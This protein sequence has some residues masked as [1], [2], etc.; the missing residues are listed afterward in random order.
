MAELK[1]IPHKEIDVDFP[2]GPAIKQNQWGENAYI[3]CPPSEF[4]FFA[5]CSTPN[6]GLEKESERSFVVRAYAKDGDD[7]VHIGLPYSFAKEK[8]YGT[9]PVTQTVEQGTMLAVI[10]YYHVSAIDAIDKMKKPLP[11]AK[12]DGST[13][14]IEDAPE[15]VP[16]GLNSTSQ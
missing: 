2:L 1:D 12:N 7:Q 11:L 10:V 6:E 9:K 8:L 3:Y 4:N 5:I 13:D 14:V 16:E 15:K